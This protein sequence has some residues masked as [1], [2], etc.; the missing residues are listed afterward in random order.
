MSDQ[1]DVNAIADVLNNKVDL[2]DGANQANVDYVIETQLP[3]AQ[4]NYTWYRLY[5][6][7]WVEQGG[8][9]TTA[10]VDTT[11]QLLKEMDNTTYHCLI[12]MDAPARPN[13]TYSIWFTYDQHSTYFKYYMS[14]G[15]SSYPMFWEVKGM[16]AQGGNQ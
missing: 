5:K 10:G 3:T 8:K 13:P 2:A 4:N 16:S 14:G 11:V 9:I 15:S 7:G 12:S 1:I 6:S